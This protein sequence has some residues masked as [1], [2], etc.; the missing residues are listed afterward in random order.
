M[1]TRIQTPVPRKRLLKD[2]NVAQVIEYLHA[3]HKPLSSS[4][5]TTKIMTIIIKVKAII[6]SNKIKE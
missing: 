3:K 6:M 4:P 2:W 1:R 5:S